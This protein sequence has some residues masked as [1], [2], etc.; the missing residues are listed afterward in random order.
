MRINM[1]TDF[2]FINRRI[3]CTE[4]PPY[5]WSRLITLRCWREY[6]YH[7]LLPLAN[8]LVSPWPTMIRLSVGTGD[9]WYLLCRRPLRSNLVWLVRLVVPKWWFHVLCGLLSLDMFKEFSL[10]KFSQ[11]FHYRGCAPA[12]IDQK[13]FKNWQIILAFMLSS[14]ET[15]YH[16]WQ[17]PFRQ[18]ILYLIRIL[19]YWSR[20]CLHKYE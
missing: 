5:A 4:F 11:F 1:S 18:E 8:P 19:K 6:G 2:Y 15:F 9:L 14:T 7:N 16:V 3:V 10:A 17:S 13:G 20:L 12:R